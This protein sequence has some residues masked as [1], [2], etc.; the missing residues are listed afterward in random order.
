V[1]SRTP[2]LTGAELSNLMNEAAIRTARFNRKKVTQEDILE[3][4]EKVLIGPARKNHILS[5]EER[6]ITA[7]HEAGH[8]IIGH[9]LPNCDPVHKISIISRGRAAGYTLNLPDNDTYLSGKA[10]F[11][12]N[13]AMILG[14]YIVE[15]EVFGNLTTGPSNDL[16]KVTAIAKGMVTRYAM[17]DAL[18]PRTYGEHDEMVFL[19]KDVH[20]EKDYS[21]KISQIIDKEIEKIINEGLNKGKALIQEKRKALDAL[22]QELLE[23]ET[24]EK[25]EFEKMMEKY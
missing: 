13:I 9:F 11:I 4:I 21:E 6:K 10:K 25:E 2:G 14:G 5:D 24:I 17:S 20:K 7:Y 3:S 18:P 23:K 12:D 1:A 15:K 22:A 19:G 8:A 16:Q